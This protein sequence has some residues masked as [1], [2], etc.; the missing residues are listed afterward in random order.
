MAKILA[1]SLDN[2]ILLNNSHTTTSPYV[3]LTVNNPSNVKLTIKDAN[4][5]DGYYKEI[6]GN[7]TAALSS[8]SFNTGGVA[9]L[10][11]LECLKLNSIFF[12][13]TLQ[14]SNVIRA[15]IDTSIQY[16]ITVSG[17]GINV[18]GS[19]SSYK[20]LSPNK[21]V[22]MLQGMIDENTRNITMEKYNNSQTVSFNITSPFKYS[23]LKKPLDISVTA[24]QMYDSKASLVTVPYQSATVMPTTLTRFQDVDYD[25]YLYTGGTKVH[26]LTNN[27]R[28]YY[29]YGEWVSLSFLSSVNIA[30]PC[31]KKNFYTNS[32]VY[33]DTE[34]TTQ[35]VEKSGENVKRYD[36]YDNFE[37]SNIEYI[38]DK[39]VGYILVYFVNGNGSTTEL[40]EP[41]RFDVIP[42]CKGNHE[43]FF[44]NEIGGIDS[45]N[46]VNTKTVDMG[47]DDQSTYFVNPI[48]NYTDRY[49]LEYTKQKRN[50]IS[51]IV[52]T[53]QIDL[54][55]AQW[56]NE[57][58]KSKYVF[59]FLG[60]QSP[61]FKTIIID[62]F[63]I[64]TNTSDDEF[65]L[66]MEYHEADNSE[67]V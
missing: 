3:T 67:N 4:N 18:G 41:V 16:S 2:F 54:S 64:S 8:D 29:N 37:L 53:N 32:G 39:Q 36:I 33:L 17:S 5:D 9:A 26:F 38:N 10:N 14:A 27:E 56:L 63:D 42:K 55:T 15:N 61:R 13:I 47:V 62:K 49:E 6:I 22:V 21:M 59:T 28:R 50:K 7:S 58:V 60:V 35:L 44:L 45:F 20:A 1:S 48:R 12:N 24:Y 52:R 11:L 31:I 40:S 30:N 57:M 46:F 66:E 19:Y 43:V 34:W 51:Q 25:K 65:E 23:S